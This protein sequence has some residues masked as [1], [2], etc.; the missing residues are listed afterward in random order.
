[1][2]IEINISEENIS[3]IVEEMIAREYLEK[4]GSDYVELRNG[5]KK[6]AE[7]ATKEYVYSEKESIIN[8]VIERA[9]REIVKKALPKL[10]DKLGEE[11]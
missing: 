7:T 3:K 2:K 11:D 1:M 8:A 9:S 10:M 4:H 5:L 6:G